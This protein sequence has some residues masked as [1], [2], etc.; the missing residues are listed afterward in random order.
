[1]KR[2]R[3]ARGGPLRR[4]RVYLAVLPI[5]IPLLIAAIRSEP[6]ASSTT[7]VASLAAPELRYEILAPPEPAALPEHS[8]VLTV[9]ANDTLDSVFTAGGLSRRDS[10]LLTQE[11]ARSIDVRRLQPGHM[12]RFHHNEH[13]VVDAVQ[14]KVTAWGDIDALRKDDGTFDVTPRPAAQSSVSATVSATIET[15][16]YEAITSAGEHPALVQQLIDIFQ[17]DIDFFALQRGDTFSLVVDKKFANDE[18]VG[19]GPILAAR[20]VHD[21]TPYE[22]FRHEAPDGRA[23]Y[24]TR[25]ATPVRKQFLRAPLKFTRITSGFS[26]R[27]FHPVL[28]YF[29]PHYGVDYGAPTGTPVMTTAD[30]VIVEMGYKGGEGN[31]VRVRHTSRTETWYLHLSRFK[32]GLKRGSKVVQGDVIGYVGSTGLASGPHLDYRVRESG[33]W[34]DPLKLRSITP[35]PLRGDS[36]R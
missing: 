13:N 18:P 23:G 14:M 32:K 5:A 20:F 4:P 11:F 22:A 16:L 21:G 36:L 30:G 6:A 28:N 29:R 19:Y 31:L 34:L 7:N 12:V 3:A 33:K 1:M 25:S 10:A 9:E 15:S 2:T 27:R 8:M 35:D 26:K 24:Y 17:W